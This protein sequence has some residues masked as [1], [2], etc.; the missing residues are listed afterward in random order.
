MRACENTTVRRSTRHVA[1]TAARGQ[2]EDVP[3]GSPP[4]VR[5]HFRELRTDLPPQW[6]KP[7]LVV[8]V[9]YRKRVACQMRTAMN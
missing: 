7:I 5:D 6:V 2:A 8:Q 9:E 4:V 3:P 1:G